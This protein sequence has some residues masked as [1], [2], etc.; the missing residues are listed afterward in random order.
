M[1]AQ[2]LGGRFKK[3]NSADELIGLE[4]TLALDAPSTFTAFGER[5]ANLGEQAR[6]LIGSLKGEGKSIAAYGAPTKA[7]TLLCQFGIGAESLDFAVDDNPWKQGLYLPLS[8]IPVVPTDEL[9]HRCPDFVVILAW[10]FAE[11]IMAM[12]QRYVDQGGRFILPMPEP[13]IV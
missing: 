7:T 8:H 9:Y 2:K 12:H 1:M 4:R 3:D 11:P 6:T 13:R 5:I 10:N